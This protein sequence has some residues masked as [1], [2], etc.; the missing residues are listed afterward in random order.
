MS[1][2]AAKFSASPATVILE[3]NQAL[4]GSTP[5]SAAIDDARSAAGR[6]ARG[7]SGQNAMTRGAITR[8][9]TDAPSGSPKAGSTSD[10]GDQHANVA[11]ATATAAAGSL[12]WS[13]DRAPK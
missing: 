10:S 4:S 2:I 11:A 1:G 6:V 9:A 13:S 3:K 7:P 5:A 12:W 8:I